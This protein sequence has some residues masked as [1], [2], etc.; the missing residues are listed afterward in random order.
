MRTA[1]Y[2]LLMLC[3]TSAIVSA[4]LYFL[5]LCALLSG[6]HSLYSGAKS[7]DLDSSCA[8]CSPDSRKT[9]AGVKGS[10]WSMCC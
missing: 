4:R 8:S 5:L 10:S 1:I 2:K 7:A 3:P 6:K 9:F